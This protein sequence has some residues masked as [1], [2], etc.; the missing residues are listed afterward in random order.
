M[1]IE[2]RR[3]YDV[4][5]QIDEGKLNADSSYMREPYFEL[6]KQFIKTLLV[7]IKANT[8]NDALFTGHST[9]H[10]RTASHVTSAA[11]R[12]IACEPTCV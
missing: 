12:T 11:I 6:D 10:A 9:R 5:I 3:L 7:R 8:I 4:S 1:F 2:N